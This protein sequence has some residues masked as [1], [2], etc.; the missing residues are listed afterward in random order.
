MKHILFFVF[1]ISLFSCG[2]DSTNI[3]A[4]FF[5]EGKLDISMVDSATVKL[6]T[7][8]LDNVTNGKDRIVVGSFDDERLG[9]IAGI[10]YVQLGISSDVTLPESDVEYESVELVMVADGYSFYDTTKAMTLSIHKVAEDIDPDISGDIY[11]D[12]SFAYEDESIGSYQFIPRP[13]RTSEIKIPLSD[14]FG[15]ELFAKAQQSHNDLSSNDEFIE[16]L[17]GLV[18]IPDTTVSSSLLGIKSS[19]ELR[20]N[21]TDRSVIPTVSRYVSFTANT[22]YSFTHFAVDRE[23]TS[24]AG[25]DGDERMAA[26]ETN[27]ESY[28]QGGISLALRVDLPYLRNFK[29]HN[30]F[31]M[32]RA[33]L[34]FYPVRKSFD[35][36]RPLPETLVCYKVDGSNE[37]YDDDVYSSGLIRDYSLE[38]DTYFVTDVTAFVKE[39]MDNISLN[40]NALVFLTTETKVNGNRLYIASPSSLYKT[41]LK[42]YYATIND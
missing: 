35:D 30:N 16:Y 4:D 20:L 3:G 2:V 24:L 17:R 15:M 12:D 13:H 21:Y 5:H 18:I 29:Q 26:D 42:I 7:I 27:D 40:E 9:K 39:Q 36:M 33:V 25:L 38:R 1:A 23:G 19:V 10:G 28:I 14:E 37:L 41:R 6:S 8:Q 11:S 34:E 22:S 31:Y 32:T